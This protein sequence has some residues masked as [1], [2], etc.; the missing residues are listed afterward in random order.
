MAARKDLRCCLVI[1]GPTAVGKSAVG[2]EVALA[3]GGEIIS[4]DS[5]QIYRGLDIGTAKPKSPRVRHWL[6]D[7]LDPRERYDAARFVRDAVEA[8]EEITSRSKV[9]IVVGGTGLYIRALTV[10]IFPGEFRDPE[11]RRSLR[12]RYES[13]EDLYSWL[14]S[15]DPEA[16]KR[17]D[18]KNYVRI[19]RALEVYIVS[20]KPI[21]YWWRTK[22][23]PPEGWRFTKI[24]ITMERT[25]LYRRIEERVLRMLEAGWVDEVKRLL[26]S[27]IEPDAPA[28]SSIGY[29]TVV[30][31]LRG[32]LEWEEMFRRITRDTKRYAR[33]QLVWFRREPNLV[34]VDATGRKTEEIAEEIIGIWRRGDSDE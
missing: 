22:T 3:L 14:A 9:P 18:P 32:E 29:R 23:K 20:G 8:M 10:G 21:S 31:Y 6:V 28:L 27:G 17:I 13:G 12:K 24:C 30:S 34:W 5:R 15:V 26:E 11:V 1:C 7:I 25:L 2:E 16:A 33:R 4:A 19:E